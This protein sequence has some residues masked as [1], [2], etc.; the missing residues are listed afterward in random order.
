MIASSFVSAALTTTC[1]VLGLTNS[2]ST[3]T[4]APAGLVRAELAGAVRVV[5][6]SA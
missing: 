2:R 1:S 6:W 4:R 5:A 3:P